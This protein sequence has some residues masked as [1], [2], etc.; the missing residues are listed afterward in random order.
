[1]WKLNDLLL[2]DFW[3]DNEIKMKILKFY[4]TNNNCDRSYY[5]FRDTT[6]TVLREKFTVLNTY[7]KK[8]RR[9][10]IDNLMSLEKKKQA[11]PKASRRKEIRKIRAE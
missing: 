8:S 6:K 10:Q 5:K 4:E 3:A 9:A 11:K 1:M 7:M 2:N